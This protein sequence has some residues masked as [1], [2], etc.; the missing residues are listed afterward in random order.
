MDPSLVAFASRLADA[1]R[2]ETLGRAFDIGNVDNKGDCAVFDP[3]TDADREAER[4]MRGLIEQQ[5]PDH[6]IAGEE[7]DDRQAQGPFTWSL[8]PIDGTRSYTC[9]LPT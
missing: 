7:F 9:G 4:A 8:D 3:V 2:A 1:A 6:G 5:H